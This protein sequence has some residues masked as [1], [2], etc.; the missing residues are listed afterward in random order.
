MSQDKLIPAVF[1]HVFSELT[2]DIAGLLEQQI[3]SSEFNQV[4][5]HVESLYWWVSSDLPSARR[6]A[7]GQGPESPH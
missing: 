3:L 1:G 4:S 6:R 5:H 2:T 7:A